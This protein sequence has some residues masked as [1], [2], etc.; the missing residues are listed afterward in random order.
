MGDGVVLV[1]TITKGVLDCC[2][3]ERHLNNGAECCLDSALW[4]DFV[5]IVQNN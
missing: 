2:A 3:G 4:N 1:R 5:S